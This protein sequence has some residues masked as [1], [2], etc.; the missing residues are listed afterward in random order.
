MLAVHKVGERYFF[1]IDNAMLGRDFLLVSRISGVPAGSN[2]TST[3][4]SSLAERMVR[5]EKR[6]NTLLVKSISVDQG[7]TARRFMPR[8]MGRATPI[9]KKT[10]HVHVV[11]SDDNT[12][13]KVKN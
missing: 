1:E 2:T 10:S 13:K 11:L 5:W 6:D 9:H 3:A 8:A 12:K 7:P 4:G